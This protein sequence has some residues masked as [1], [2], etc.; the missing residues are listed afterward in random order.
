MN[1]VPK[2]VFF[3]KGVGNHR[4]EL[5]SFELALRDAGVETQNLVTVSSILPP[6]CK[7]ISKEKGRK[8]LSHGQ[9][10][11]CVMSRNSSNEHGRLLAVSIGCAVPSDKNSYGYLSEHHSYGQSDKSAGDFAEDLA[12]EMLA[13]TL[14]IE[15][16]QNLKWDD[17]K[18]IYK[19]NDK[20]VKTANIT[21][22]T[23]AKGQGSWSTVLALAVFIL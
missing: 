6:N 10:T 23:I 14:G 21:Q 15:I 16:D 9:I 17:K 3:T 18:E 20:I 5:Q 8:F 19:M 1:F 7:I 4:K 2:Y 12:A 13:S 22:S 11:F